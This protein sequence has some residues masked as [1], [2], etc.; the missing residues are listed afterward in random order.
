MVGMLWGASLLECFSTRL[1]MILESFSHH[2]VTVP[3]HE[4]T[5][6]KERETLNERGCYGWIVTVACF[7][8][9][10]V[11]WHVFD[12]VLGWSGY[13]FASFCNGSRPWEHNKKHNTAI[14]IYVHIYIYIY[15]YKQMQKEIS[16]WN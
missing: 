12:I 14:Y 9:E 7:G 10:R 1:G 4:N 15:M 2:F 6:E 13:R 16:L 11:C 8:M 5:T 3:G